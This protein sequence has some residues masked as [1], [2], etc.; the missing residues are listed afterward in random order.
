MREKQKKQND[1]C[2]K[3]QIVFIM[4]QQTARSYI[5]PRSIESYIDFKFVFFNTY[6]PF[7]HQ[8]DSFL[9]RKKPEKISV[10]R[11]FVLR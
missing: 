8:N 6:L 2:L 5:K 10:S 7:G 4:S 11:K 1:F 3:A 9:V